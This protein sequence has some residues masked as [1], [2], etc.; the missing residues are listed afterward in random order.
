MA[1]VIDD[2]INSMIENL[3]AKTG[4]SLDDWLKIAASTG[5]TK[6]GEVLGAL[7]KEHGLTHGYANLV[8]RRFLQAEN[9]EPTSPEGMVTALFAGAKAGLKPL[10]DA[11]IAIAESFGPDVLVDPKKTYVSL[12]RKKQFA[13]VMPS[14]AKRLDLGLNLKGAL[15][16]GRLEASGSF[17]AMCTHRVR[18]ESNA[19]F[20][21]EIIAWLKLAYQ[22]AS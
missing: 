11:V 14:T 9:D 21:A 13:L 18:L 5:K 22:S 15:P 16:T 8:S 7:K 1:K 6:H 17:N 3:K 12:R 2:A 19:D 4:K 20:D 10:F